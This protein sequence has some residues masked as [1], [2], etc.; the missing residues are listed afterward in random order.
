MP[1]VQEVKPKVQ[2]VKEAPKKEE[3]KAKEEEPKVQEVKEAPK[4]EEP[5]AEDKAQQEIYDDIYLGLRAYDSWKKKLTDQLNSDLEKNGQILEGNG[6]LKKSLQDLINILRDD[7]KNTNEIINGFKDVNDKAEAYRKSVAKNIKKLPKDNPRVKL[8]E[9]AKDKITQIQ[10]SLMNFKTY[11]SLIGST[12]METKDNI[13]FREAGIADI[14][15]KLNSLGAKDNQAKNTPDKV[16][17]LSD[18]IA[19]AT[20]M[21]IRILNKIKND[22]KVKLDLTESNT[23]KY[24]LIKSS[25]PS[26]R[27]LANQYIFTS[28]TE[29]TLSKRAIEDPERLESIFRR[30]N[31]K[32]FISKKIDSFV[33][34]PVF[35]DFSKQH[36]EDCFSAWQGVK[37]EVKELR[38]EY[39]DRLKD[40]EGKNLYKFIMG[41][42]NSD[43]KDWN[44]M[45]NRYLRFASVMTA[46]ILS[47]KNNKLLLQGVVT[48][49]YDLM[50]IEER[51]HDA[52][53]ER[54]LLDGLT[55]FAI[56]ATSF[57]LDYNSGE[58]EKNIYSKLLADKNIKIPEAPKQN[59][60]KAVENNAPKK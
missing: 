55:G 52:L 48:G 25:K 43:I 45:E 1:K 27:D 2:E 39:A 7:K 59:V 50:A 3:I 30:V 40:Y 38:Q 14:K 44:S 29:K 36:P 58:I 32:N 47:D 57:N 10:N 8:D 35:K 12:A 33:K 34:N 20:E 19:N 31:D 26:V 15:E 23:D 51:I 6:D 49:K 17:K 16:K 22:H 54:K 46:K 56:G 9:F 21:Q 18:D 11:K 28:Y 24:I 5:A 13:S 4:K 37:K 53:K 42:E 41:D 60:Q